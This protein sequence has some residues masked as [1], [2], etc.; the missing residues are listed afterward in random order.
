M[1]I[2]LAV[3]IVMVFATGARAQ[4]WTRPQ[5]ILRQSPL[6]I[7]TAKGPVHFTVELAATPE[8][9]ERGLMFRR[10]VGA[11]AGMLFDFHE[12]RD[13]AFWMKNTLVP[14]DMVFIRANGRIARIAANTT[15]LS[16]ENI[17]AGEPVAAVLEI[18]GGRADA[19]GIK[20]GCLVRHGIFG[21][22]R[23]P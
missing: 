18:A 5:P 11:N 9:R 3:L 6:V 19:L 23:A 2:V 21:N 1:R 4:E 15:P 10:H 17:P 12:V 14:L 7:E 20:P 22:W 16:T 13:I 8:A